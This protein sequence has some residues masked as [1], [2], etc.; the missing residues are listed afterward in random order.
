MRE[1]GAVVGN[2]VRRSLTSADIPETTF[3]ALADRAED[4]WPSPWREA[5]LDCIE[6][7][8]VI[9]TPIAEYVPDQLVNGRLA[10]V[11]DAAHVPTPMTGSGFSASLHD[12]EAVAAAV[13]AGVRGPAMAQA[14]RGYEDERLGSVRSMVRSDRQFSRS[15]AG[16]AAWVTAAPR[17]EVAAIRRKCGLWW[18]RAKAGRKA[19]HRA[20]LTPYSR[21]AG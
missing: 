19:D 8:A 1:T 2:V 16:D 6:R 12:A 4:L 10:L 15:C 7:R 9:G 5:V 21:A 11:G 20:R 3:R 13:A 18:T 17:G 14:L